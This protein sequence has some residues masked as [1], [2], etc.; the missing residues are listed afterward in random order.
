M[1]KL[2]FFLT[3]YLPLLAYTQAPEGRDDFSSDFS[4]GRFLDPMKNCVVDE[5][6]PL[7]YPPEKANLCN[8][9][10]VQKQEEETD[11]PLIFKNPEN[12]KPGVSI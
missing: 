5:N 10:E 3:L 9:D 2:I 6:R 7:I 1:R 4:P 12:Q 8:F 11:R